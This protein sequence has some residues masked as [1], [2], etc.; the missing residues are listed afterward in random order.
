M[1]AEV[2]EGELWVEPDTP[3]IRG[4]LE[5][6]IHAE[7]LHRPVKKTVQVRGRTKP[8]DVNEFAQ[9]VIRSAAKRK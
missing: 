3:E 7:N 1:A 2:F 8:F 6:E 4:V 5:L 9:G